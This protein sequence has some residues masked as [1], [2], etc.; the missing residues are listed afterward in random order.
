MGVGGTV[1]ST[2]EILVRCIL[3]GKQQMWRPVTRWDM[4]HF[5]RDGRRRHARV[6]VCRGGRLVDLA[7]K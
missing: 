7:G 1:G 2:E 4:L 5:R 3:P 6:C